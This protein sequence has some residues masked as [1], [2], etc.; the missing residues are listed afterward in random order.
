MRV[1]P[2]LAGLLLVSAS[3]FAQAGPIDRWGG[4]KEGSWVKAKI[5]H[6]VNGKKQEIETTRTVS[7]IQADQIVLSVENSSG[8]KGALFR[9]RRDLLSAIGSTNA[10]VVEKKDLDV[11]EIPVGSKI[12]KCSTHELHWKL[13]KDAKTVDTLKL[14]E[15]DEAPGRLVKVEGTFHDAGVKEGRGW[16]HSG[17]ITALDEKMT[18][19]G[20]ELSCALFESTA[21]GPGQWTDKVW[22][23]RDLPGMILRSLGH[24]DDGTKKESTE[25]SVVEFEAKK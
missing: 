10:V 2:T 21:T 22:I 12:L 13:S 25:W 9:M 17:K 15:S 24:R 11:E 4:F 6:E 8:A 23:S 18:V 16:K 14:W 7:Q 3:A 5:T 20:K 19:A 1:A